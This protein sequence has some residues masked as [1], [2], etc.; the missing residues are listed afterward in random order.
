M[1]P[2]SRAAGSRRF[3]THPRPMLFGRLARGGDLNGGGGGKSLA[4]A[5]EG[6][7]WRRLGP[8][9]APS[10]VLVFAPHE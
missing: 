9:R 1:H 10:S 6:S 8:K 5:L 7:S 2:S 4:R 3:L